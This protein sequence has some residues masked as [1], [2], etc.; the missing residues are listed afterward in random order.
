M[1]RSGRWSLTTPR[2]PISSESRLPLLEYEYVDQ[3][4]ARQDLND[5]AITEDVEIY[6]QIYIQTISDSIERVRI[7]PPPGDEANMTP[8]PRKGILKPP[9]EK[10]PEEPA[11]IREGVAPLKYAKLDGIPA[12]ARWTKISR[13]IVSPEALKLGM[14]R[15]E[16]REDFV[17]VLRVLSRDEIQGYA[18]VTQRIR[19]LFDV[20]KA[21]CSTLTPYAAGREEAN[22]NSDTALKDTFSEPEVGGFGGA[23]DGNDEEGAGPGAS[24]HT[25]EYE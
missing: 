22:D 4:K 20:F 16:A 1:F 8:M 23:G 7:V 25:D 5:D 18:D 12:D 2:P 19:G 13:N 17:I 10:F 15:F 14:E 3:D 21:P 11:P 9:K 24:R 6:R